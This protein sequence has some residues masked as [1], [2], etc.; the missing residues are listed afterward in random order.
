[1]YHTNPQST[2]CTANRP[3]STGSPWGKNKAACVNLM[4]DVGFVD[5]ANGNYRLA[6]SSQGKGR[7]TDGRDVGAD[8]DMIVQKTAGVK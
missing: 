2:Y 5:L 8:I 6:P 7:A 3:L 4:S 1:V